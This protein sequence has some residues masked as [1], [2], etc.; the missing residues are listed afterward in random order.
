M[1]AHRKYRGLKFR[2]GLHQFKVGP[3]IITKI[4][5]SKGKQDL[6]GLGF[7]YLKWVPLGL[8]FMTSNPISR[9]LVGVQ[10]SSVIPS[11]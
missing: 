4:T 2:P 3:T 1:T 9:F 10:H 7:V 11:A 8:R 6:I 5:G